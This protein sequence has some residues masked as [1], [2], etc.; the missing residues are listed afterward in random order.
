MKRLTKKLAT[1]AL[2]GCLVL[3]YTQQRSCAQEREPLEHR[4]LIVH[5][6]GTWTELQDLE[7]VSVGGINTDDEPVPSFVHTISSRLLESTVEPWRVKVPFFGK[8]VRRLQA[9][10]SRLETP[11]VYFYPPTHE[12]KPLSVDVEVQLRG[13]W[14]S[15]FYPRATANAPGLGREQLDRYMA[16]SLKWENLQVGRT[17]VFGKEATSQMP[18]TDEHVWLAPRKT[19]AAMVRTAPPAAQDNQSLKAESEKYLF[20]RGV[21][22][23][24]GP[25]RIKTDLEHDQLQ[26]TSHFY[27]LGADKTLQIP[28]SWLVHVDEKGEVAFR[29]LDSMSAPHDRI[30]TLG[31][32]RR[33]FESEDFS[34]GNLELL[35]SKMHAALTQDGL[36]ADEAH[37]MLETWRDAYFKSPGLRLFYVVPPEWTNHRM[38]LTLSQSATIDRVMVGR[39]ELVADHQLDILAQLKK[40]PVRENAGWS[41]AISQLGQPTEAN[42]TGNQKLVAVGGRLLPWR[43]STRGT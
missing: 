13:G 24:D 42:P 7:G 29:S 15:E 40:T 43:E 5:E 3:S 20:Y 27:K 25:L 8:S 41:N 37:A 30:A 32:V 39:I 12:T 17:E 16:G 26:L 18:A 31:Q 22:N 6:W 33:G 9:I 11:V 14:L 38:P 1:T 23:F 35:R 4:D 36:Y 10:T 21:G 19:A 2:F 34:K 28:A